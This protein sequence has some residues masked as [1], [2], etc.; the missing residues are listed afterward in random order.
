MSKNAIQFQPGMSLPT[1]LERYG[2]E[3]QCREALMRMRWPGGF[4]CP[5]CGYAGHCQL[6]GRPVLQCNRCK[7]Q[8][9][10]TAGTPFTRTHLPPQAGHALH[11]TYHALNP[12][13]CNAPHPA[14]AVPAANPGPG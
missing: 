13:T 4:R 14:T 10:M 1:F 12:N 11:G 3:A 7:H 2:S 5:H 9:S 8:A 6:R